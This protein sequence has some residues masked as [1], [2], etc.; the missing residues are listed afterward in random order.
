MFGR[1]LTADDAKRCGLVSD[2]LPPDQ[3]LAHV[4][5]GDV[6]RRGERESTRARTGLLVTLSR[7]WLI[8]CPGQQ[9]Y[10]QIEAGLA[11]P[12]SEKSLPLFK[13]LVRGPRRALLLEVCR[14]ELTALDKRAADGDI[15]TAVM[16]LMSSKSKL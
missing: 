11:F 7:G 12:L 2:V 4:R 9:T 6:Q 16:Q 10:K 3:L 5:D 15:M 1:K 13:D 14:R 8:A